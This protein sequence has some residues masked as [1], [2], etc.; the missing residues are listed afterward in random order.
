[1]VSSPAHVKE[2]NA[3]SEHDLSLPAYLVDVSN[4]RAYSTVVI[5]SQMCDRFFSI[6]ILYLSSLR[7]LY[8]GT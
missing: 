8:S 5:Y 1:M 4:A 3:A 2:V 6:A 7:T